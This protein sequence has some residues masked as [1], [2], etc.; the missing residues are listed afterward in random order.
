MGAPTPAVPSLP[1][2]DAEAVQW[3]AERQVFSVL[4]VMKGGTCALRNHLRA[5]AWENG[6]LLPSREV[7]FFDDDTEHAKGALHYT[8]L[9]TGGEDEVKD[10]EGSWRWHSS[11]SS[12]NDGGGWWQRASGNWND[13]S[14]SQWND[15]SSSQWQQSSMA[16]EGNNNN[17][18]RQWWRS[19]K[20]IGDITPSYLYIPAAVPRLRQI[21][22]H[23]RL[24]V[25][26]R[27]PVDR[28]LSHHNHDLAKKRD[29]GRLRQRWEQ[30]LAADR[31]PSR[32]DVFAR[33]LY[34]EQLQRIFK[35]FPWDQVLVVISERYR[36]HT[37]Q[38]LSR[39]CAFL[40]LG[41][42]SCCKQAEWQPE[43]H[44]RG[45]YLEILLESDRNALR[46]L[47][48]QD[49]QRLKELLCDPIPEWTDFVAA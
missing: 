37:M 21:I 13:E 39:V 33:G 6:L 7:H 44:V 23:S 48:V 22:P 11:W 5:S 3:L 45:E 28:A 34:Y 24:I 4:G 29:V 30:E 1:K 49:V 36:K 18:N 26:L 9:L 40:G 35:H 38:E 41:A 19:P 43:T 15:G 47:Y 2:D 8:S 32:W 46:D 42:T 12:W 14:S 10:E 16:N 17:N 20:A 31:P 25:M 27:N